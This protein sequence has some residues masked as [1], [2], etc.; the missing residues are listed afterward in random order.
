MKWLKCNIPALA[1]IKRADICGKK[2]ASI[3]IGSHTTRMLIAE[4]SDSPKVFKALARRRVYTNLAEGFKG[5]EKGDISEE[6]IARTTYA[7]RAFAGLAKKYGVDEFYAVST[8]VARRAVNSK[9]FIDSAKKKSGIDVEII[10]GER[11][12][13]LTRRGVAYGSGAVE[14]GSHV[15]FDLGGATTE[16]IWGRENALK[17]KSL[18]IGALILTQ[19]YF[20]SDPPGEDKV[21]ALSNSIDTILDQG[22]SV[23]ASG[24][25]NVLLT[26]SGGTATTLAAI[27]NRFGVREIVPEKINGLVVERDQ[28][29]N[30]FNRM[31]SM[32]LSRR[33][34][35][36]GMEQGRAGVILAGALSILRIMNFFNIKEMKVSYSDIL[37][38]ILISYILGERQ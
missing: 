7:L 6:A 25:H 33:R 18:P 3:D 16:F 4:F 30:L 8:G 13:L 23:E 31:S 26:G 9:Y 5:G 32:P 27:I 22:L 28:I 29:Q 24:L 11:E 36:K 35:I 34:R 10:S 38:G 14:S 1:P 15:I 17:I 20:D 21:L 12:G 19:G 2:I 37:E